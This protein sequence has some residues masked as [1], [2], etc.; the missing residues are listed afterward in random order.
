MLMS[1][2][3]SPQS[4]GFCA[5]LMELENAII[6]HSLIEFTKVLREFPV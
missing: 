1:V 2:L 4:F 3:Q 6:I 5:L